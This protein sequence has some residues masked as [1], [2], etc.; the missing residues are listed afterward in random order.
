[1]IAELKNCV[2][3]TGKTHGVTKGLDSKIAGNCTFAAPDKNERHAATLNN[4]I[5]HKWCKNV[6]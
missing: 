2:F 5:K 6:N 3:L 1:M 4:S